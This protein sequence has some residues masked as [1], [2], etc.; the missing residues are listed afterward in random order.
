MPR[1][2]AAAMAQLV[3]PNIGSWA[4]ESG[5]TNH[6]GIAHASSVANIRRRFP[7]GPKG[8]PPRRSDSPQAQCR[9]EDGF[10]DPHSEQRR[11]L[12]EGMAVSL[13]VQH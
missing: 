13:P 5:S 11:S 2:T 8:A 4:L 3:R 6:R 7:R 9:S 1:A 10:Q 12:F